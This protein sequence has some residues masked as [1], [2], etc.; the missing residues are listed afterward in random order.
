MKKLWGDNYYDPQKRSWNT[1][2]R[3][4]EGKTL[5]RGFV[6]F[7]MTPIVELSNNIMQGNLDKV[8]GMTKKLG[9]E[10][11][12]EEKQ[13]RG[14]DL[15]RNIFKKWINA[16]EALLEMII[17]KLPSPK[18]AQAYRAAQLYEGPVDDECGQAIKNCDKDGPLMVFISKMVPINDT[19]RFYA[20]GRV[21]SGTVTSGQKVRIMGP[22]YKKGGREDLYIKNI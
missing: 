8:W 22:N 21:F 19:G 20:F 6:R 2:G 18:Q 7:I 16:A 1:T 13:L 11:K 5:D 9:I 15:F 3:T 10:M 17:T 4:E 14:K 12:E